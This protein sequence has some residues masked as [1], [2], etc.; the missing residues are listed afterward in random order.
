MSLHAEKTNHFYVC[1]CRLFASA[2][3]AAESIEGIPLMHNMDENI[4]LRMLC[5]CACFCLKAGPF[6]NSLKASD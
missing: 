1:I 2:A 3:A 6:N 5:T 4:Y